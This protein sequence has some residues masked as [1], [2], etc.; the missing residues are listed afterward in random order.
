MYHYSFSVG[1]FNAIT[2]SVVIISY[3]AYVVG[4]ST[5]IASV[6]IIPYT[7]SVVGNSSIT[8]SVVLVIFL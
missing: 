6:V 5:F 3:T 7:A 1:V 4:N 8:A 2:A